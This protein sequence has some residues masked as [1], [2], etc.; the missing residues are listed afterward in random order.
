MKTFRRRPLAAVLAAAC[1]L[2][3]ITPSQAADIK[4]RSF[5]IASAQT[6]EHPFSN[7][8]QKFAELI[9]AKSGG[10][11]KAKLFPGGTL[12]GD[13][14]VISSLQGGTVDMTMVS[15]GPARRA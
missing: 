5:K 15:T 10:K 12:G 4:E 9:A 1:T 11:I 2:S 14:A 3:P 8:A 6:A 13:A 7:G